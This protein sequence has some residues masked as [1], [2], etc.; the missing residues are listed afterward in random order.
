MERKFD[1]FVEK[2]GATTK[3]DN[4]ITFDVWHIKDLMRNKIDNIR[5][6]VFYVNIQNDEEY[7][8]NNYF[9]MSDL[10]NDGIAHNDNYNNNIIGIL[11]NSNNIVS[12]LL[13]FETFEGD[14]LRVNNQFRSFWIEDDNKNILDF[15]EKK[16]SIGVRIKYTEK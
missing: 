14:N 11:G 7:K 16:W 2:T 5:I 3:D 10:T 13:P 6:S 9:I 4:K 15:G 12:Q 8:T 1:I